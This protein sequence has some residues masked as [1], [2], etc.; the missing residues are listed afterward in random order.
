MSKLGT[1]GDHV[2]LQAAADVYH[3]GICIVTSFLENCV[4]TIRCA[5]SC[6]LEGVGGEA[7]HLARAFRTII[8][9]AH[10]P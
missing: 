1:W 7:G 9:V 4:I 2:T 3:V 10:R 8:T 5:R 6:V